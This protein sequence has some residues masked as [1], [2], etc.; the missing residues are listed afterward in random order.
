MPWYEAE[1]QTLKQ[2]INCSRPYVIS[3]AAIDYQ[4]NE[5]TISWLSVFLNLTFHLLAFSSV[6]E[7]STIDVS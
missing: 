2:I 5:C 7:P 3:L 1:K 4:G 6:K